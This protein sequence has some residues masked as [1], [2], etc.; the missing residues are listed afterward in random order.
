MIRRK[1]YKWK[2]NTF[3]NNFQIIV[4]KISDSEAERILTK[5]DF[6]SVS[7]EVLYKLNLE[8]IVE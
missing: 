7:K 6:N 3:S 8:H 2:C 4:K 1:Y 5:G